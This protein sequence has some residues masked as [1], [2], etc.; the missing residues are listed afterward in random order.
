MTLQA[1]NPLKYYS[2]RIQTAKATHIITSHAINL[3]PSYQR[4][5]KNKLSY[6]S[7]P[8]K[9][10]YCW[11][12]VKILKVTSL[13]KKTQNGV[14]V[15]NRKKGKVK[16]DQKKKTSSCKTNDEWRH[17]YLL[18]GRDYADGKGRRKGCAINLQQKERQGSV[19]L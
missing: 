15:Y 6:I 17:A 16:E 8:D 18:F 1:P 3:H 2:W 19:L 4:M 9:Y 7:T 5:S 14:L 11:A 12:L 10:L 13:H